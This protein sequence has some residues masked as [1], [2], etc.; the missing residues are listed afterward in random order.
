[1]KLS[2]FDYVLP[3]ELIAQVPVE[4]R[5]AS[6][7]MV[8][9][10]GVDWRTEGFEHRHFFDLPEFLGPG[11]VLVFNE[12]K[13][14]PARISF[15]YKE[16]ECEMFFLRVSNVNEWE[17]MVRPGKFFREG[18]V[19]QIDENVSVEVLS[20]MSE[21]E[22]GHRIVGVSDVLVRDTFDLLEQIGTIP[23]P[24][25]IESTEGVD[26]Y[27][28]VYARVPGSV[29][30]PTAG[31]HFTEELLGRLRERGVQMEYVTLHVGAGTFLPVSAE[32]IT[33]HIMHREYYSIAPDVLERLQSY[34]KSGKRIFAVGTT[35]CR[36]LES[37]F[38]N[39]DEPVPEGSTKLF[40]YPGYEFK[41]I[42]ALVTNFH[43]PKSTLLMLVSALAGYDRI[44]AAYREAVAQRYRFFSFGDGMIIF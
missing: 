19:V 17:V 39:P 15:M 35:A 42:D 28:T 27:Q 44:R 37:C 11:D 31:F 22:H 41:F 8:I 6:K 24:P 3:K 9:D 38:Q 7:L 2:E 29:A 20:V 12:S 30:A 5:D 4:P 10:R 32:I 43:L 25:Y 18:A 16:K 34:K 23:L 26:L 14:I 1:M 33:D 13:V 40:I 36:T 21:E